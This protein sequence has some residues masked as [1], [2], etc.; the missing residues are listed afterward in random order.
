MP[1][2][3]IGRPEGGRPP[4]PRPR[5]GRALA[6]VRQ[7]QRERGLVDGAET[8]RHLDA[9]EELRR[10][11]AAPAPAGGGGG[12]GGGGPAPAPAP[13]SRGW[14]ALGPFSIP[15]GQTK[16]GG[17]DPR[18]SVAGRIS[19]VAIDPGDARHIL[20][21]AAGGGVWESRDAGET[22]TARTDSQ[23]S[24]A[25][26]ALA[27]DPS[28]PATVY[29]GTG[30]G[31]ALWWLGAGLLRSADGG[32]R[33]NLLIGPPFAGG[34]FFDLLVDPL[35]S[36]H[37]LA[38][39]GRSA[40][41][42]LAGEL[43]ESTN[44]GTVWHRRRAQATW[45]ISMHPADP[46]DPDSTNEVF[47]GSQDG[48]FVSPDGG[49][50]WNPVALPGAPAAG[51]DR[52]EVRHA[53]SN[54]DVV[55]VFASGL[56]AAGASHRGYLWR[57]SA[58]GGAFT[59][60]APPGDLDVGQAWYD[61]VAAVSPD[62]PDVLYLGA[63]DL[64]RGDRAATGTWTW[65]K[66][67]PKP[68]GDS[69]HSDQHALAFSP[70]DPDTLYV[71]NDGGLYRSPDRGVSW[72]SLNKGLAITEFEYLA[73]HPQHA[74]WLLGGTQDNGTQRYEG[75]AVWY[76]VADGDGGDC[77]VNAAG[78]Y[79]GFHT[80]YEMGMDRSGTGGGWG[81]WT[82]IGPDVPQ[83]YQSLFYPPVEVSGPVVAQAGTSVYV[84]RDAGATWEQHALPLPANDVV[85]AL[86][87]PTPNR[88]Y[89]GTSTGLVF[90]LDYSGGA[91]Q[92]PVALARPRVGYLSDIA[93][94]PRNPS[95]LWATFSTIAGAHVFR[96]DN[97]GTGWVN[98][99]AG[100]PGIGFN[101]VE[102]DPADGNTVW[103]AADLG[104]YR[105]PD[106]GANWAPFNDRLPNALVKDLVLH[107]PTRRL[108]AAT[109]SRGVWEIDIDDP[110]LPDVALFLRDDA[111]DDGRVAPPGSGVAD[112]FERGALTY[113]WESPDVKTDAPPYVR[114]T[115]DFEL[116]GDDHGV[117]AAGL[118]H[119]NPR[120]GERARVHVEV[121][122][123]GAKDATG[124]AV[125]VFALPTPVAPPG[126]P[127]A[128]WT[129]F[130]ANTPPADSPWQPIGPHAVVPRIE[131]GRSAVA[132]FD[133]PLAAEAADQFCLLAAVSATGDALSTTERDVARAVLGNVKVAL[134]N[135][136]VVHPPPFRGPRASAVRAGV[137]GARGAGRYTLSVGERSLSLVEG[138]VLSTDLSA[139]AVSAGL[140][141]APLSPERAAEIARLVTRFP[142]L[143]GKLD[144]TMAWIPPP[145]GPWLEDVDLSPSQPEP[146]VLLVERNPRRGRWTVVQTA[147]DGAVVGGLTLVSAP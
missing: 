8:G 147:Q 39:T 130:P 37:L 78:P 50:T 109:Q 105:T 97:G 17:F 77:G 52:I 140:P 34:G 33:W 64:Y 83:G 94:D 90:R 91:W 28:S 75:K 84:S 24:L 5:G 136:V 118:R 95:R 80:Y 23:P 125:R 43:Y 76:H 55:Y 57:R 101:A 143:A 108:R 111:V 132:S 53:P 137:W 82:W 41:A 45:S 59:T 20:V 74:T 71:G 117:A 62:D 134:R 68:T 35:D 61:W 69:V 102:I 100:L 32:E 116:F 19:S 63:L 110:T 7:Q 135:V 122:N 48:L 72:V 15:H 131:P 9:F 26:G 49:T 146:I 144:Q 2:D 106:A 16:V 79:T 65:T 29:A 18:P 128:F 92:A 22:W 73:Q 4:S 13:P 86:T 67:S 56:P 12:G 81:S 93:V 60:F 115:V 123:R 3:D 47:A 42:T 141:Q 127:P 103:V 96:S 121:H 25:V 44:G 1:A 46:A 104:V 126:L 89:A 10:L 114:A 21:G 27:F 85:T 54:G 6:R 139:A 145:R 58:A 124:V 119:E 40:G 51:W 11:T 88:I 107:V 70:S 31:D 112:P 66:I 133:W 87:M 36:N 120:P 14:R 98:V 99:S 30:E 129:G 113:W 138:V 142:D 38:G